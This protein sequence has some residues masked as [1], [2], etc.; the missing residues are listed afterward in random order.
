MSLLEFRC[1]LRQVALLAK[2]QPK[3]IV[4]RSKVRRELERRPELFDGPL[5]IAP[6][7]FRSAQRGAH[8]RPVRLK[9][10]SPLVEGDGSIQIPTEFKSTAHVPIGLREL[11]GERDGFAELHDGGVRLAVLQISPAKR[12]VYDSVFGSVH[13]CPAEL[14]DR[15]VQISSLEGRVPPSIVLIRKRVGTQ[16]P[17]LA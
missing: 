2:R 1:R 4:S 5:E 13:H 3:L 16:H 6:A 8:F 9:A 10:K 15:L 17:L 14:L 11:G 12:I 7:Q